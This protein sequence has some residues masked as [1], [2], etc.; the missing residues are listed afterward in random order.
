MGTDVNRRS[1]QS[2]WD[3]IDFSITA[4]FLKASTGGR[5]ATTE[6]GTDGQE[7]RAKAKCW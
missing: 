2:V 6:V 3:C 5:D 1:D 7:A 4:S